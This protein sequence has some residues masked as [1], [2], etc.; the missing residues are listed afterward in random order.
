MG[1]LVLPAYV[2]LALLFG[3]YYAS[4]G[5]ESERRPLPRTPIQTAP[6]LARTPPPAVAG[7]CPPP[8]G[9]IPR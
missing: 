6:E 2:A 7:P 1:R 3:Y 9:A 5:E 4:L 8:P